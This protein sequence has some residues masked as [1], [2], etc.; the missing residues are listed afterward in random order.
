MK[1]DEFERLVLELWMKTRIP[2]T[3]AHIQFHTGQK[4]KRIRKWLDELVVE[5][6]LELEVS[7]AGEMMWKVPGAARPID[8]PASFEELE[9][10]DAIRQEARRRVR[11]RRSG[12]KPK[13]QA[14]ESEDDDPGVSLALTKKA[15]S[16]AGK[17]TGALDKKRG[18]GDKSLLL[19]A[20]LG[21]LGPIG[22]LYSGSFK[23][24]IPGTLLQ[25]VVAALVPS[26]LLMPV[27]LVALPLSSLAGLLYAWGYNRNGQR[28]TLFLESEDDEE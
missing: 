5:G 12:Q 27:L 16:L 17:A 15:L 26:F 3:R 7:N 22:W 10:R 18:E 20:G 4:A 2:L 25:L 19:A 6:E 1:R 21:L 28:G 24:A 14:P 13:K 9:R 11:A 23:E 8:G